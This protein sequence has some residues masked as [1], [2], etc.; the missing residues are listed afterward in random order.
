MAVDVRHAAA[1]FSVR[2]LA[3]PGAGAELASGLPDLAAATDFAVDWLDREDP[4]REGSVRLV[5]VRIDDAGVHT[6]LTYPPDAPDR[7][8]GLVAVFGFDPTTWQP[9]DMNRPPKEELRRRLP[10]SPRPAAPK[11]DVALPVESAP[12]GT[13]LVETAPVQI[14]PVYSAPVEPEPVELEPAAL[15]PDRRDWV[16]LAK[17][18][19]ALM[20]S[21]WDD[22]YS[23]AF[24]IAAGVSMWLSVTL[25]EPVF[26]VIGLAMSGALWARQRQ[27]QGVEPDDDFDF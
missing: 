15:E 6:V 19:S 14:E 13:A 9:H 12:V 21:S 2:L 3:E 4:L 1:H 24:L 5:I 27:L 7:S 18:A 8:P 26:F 23:R 22:G 17:G 16:D 25:F 10:S 11:P 20:R